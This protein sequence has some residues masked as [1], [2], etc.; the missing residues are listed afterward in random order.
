[1][2]LLTDRTA[3]P[4]QRAVLVSVAAVLLIF[5][6][7]ACRASHQWQ[8]EPPCMPPNYSVSPSNAKTGET[9]TVQ[10]RDAD[11]NPRYGQDAL[12]KVIVTDAAG[13]KVIK[14]TAPM[15]DAGG[16]TFQF[17]VP[18]QAAAGEASVE[19]VPSALDWCDDTGRNNRIPQ[20]SA[21]QRVSCAARSVPL[22]ITP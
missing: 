15:S 6:P 14:E 20:S 21:I 16:F 1:M 8:A 3:Q 9:V 7:T 4:R 17:A 22:T 18:Q 13:Q 12:I 5:A 19:A 10:A 2:A 11:C